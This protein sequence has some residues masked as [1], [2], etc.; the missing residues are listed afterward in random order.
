MESNV[1]LTEIQQFYKNRTFFLTGITGLLGKLVLEKILRSFQ[2]KRI[3][4]LVRDKDGSDA[5]T[6]CAAAM[7]SMAFGPL[8]R[9]DP[10]FF[11]KVSLIVGDCE[12]PDLG[13][14]EYDKNLIMSEV[15][16][17]FHCAAT[18]DLGASLKK[19]ALTNVKATRDLLDIAK[20]MKNL[21]TF[22]YIS[23]VH[24]NFPQYE[25]HEKFYDLTGG[26]LVEILEFSNDQILDERASELLQGWPNA[27]A[28]TM[29][30]AEDVI[31]R[32]GKSLPLCVIRPSLM[33]SS[34]EEPVTGYI[35]GISGL[36]GATVSY[37]LG[38]NRVNYYENGTLDIVPVDYVVSIVVAAGWYTGLQNIRMGKGESSTTEPPIYHCISSQEKPVTTDE[39]MGV[40]ETECKEVPSVKMCQLPMSF[41]TACYQNYMLLTFLL[42]TCMAFLCDICLKFVGKKPVIMDIYKKL[43]KD[44]ENFRPYLLRQW[45]F[46]NDNTQKLLKRMSFKDRELFNFDILT[47]NWQAYFVNYVR[48]VRV[49]L[50]KD[51]LSTV[52]EGKKKQEKKFMVQVITASF[53]C[54]ALYIIG[55]I[56]L[57]KVIFKLFRKY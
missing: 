35:E 39:W 13:L 18:V 45:Y 51:P 29:N 28:Y 1:E 57:Y 2:V 9:V 17:I 20:Q 46:S 31:R 21:K 56:L 37:A 44:Q 14:N 42:H 7:D 55:K 32:H 19:A 33:V 23:S 8:R 48:G 26:K 38:I 52:T 11:N 36:Q 30:V 34:A 4:V 24:S 15:E 53:I 12:K 6:R 3:Y 41:Q 25:I 49:Y 50:L 10:E 43:H 27:V 54:V 22:V 40:T 5:E 47:L 16:C